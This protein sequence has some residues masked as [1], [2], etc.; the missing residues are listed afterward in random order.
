MI[1]ISICQQRVPHYRI[2]V[3]DL[4]ARQPGIEV[5]VF[6]DVSRNAPALRE[7]PEGS[8]FRVIDAPPRRVRAVPG[9]FMTHAAHRPAVDPNRFDLA[10]MQ[11]DLH[12]AL[13][14]RPALK[15]ARRRGVKTVLWG[16][17]YSKTSGSF[18]ATLR[19]GL[20]RRADGVL[21]YSH[22][23]AEQLRASKEV[24]PA[25]IFVAQNALD[26]APIARASASWRARG[27]ELEAFRREHGL[28][29]GPVAVYV[30]RLL[31][32]NRIELLIDALAIVNRSRPDAKLV[33]VGDGPARADLEAQADRLGVADRL[34]FTG[35]I[36]ED[37]R[38]APWMLSARA[39]V[40][41]VNI[42]L[43]LM[44]AMGY[45]LPVITSDRIIDHGPEV[46]ALRDGEN[47]LFY[48]HG[49]VDDFAS[50]W[51]RVIEDE[52]FQARLS[53]EALR[54]MTERYTLANMVQ[55]FLNAASLVDGASRT[56]VAED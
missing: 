33:I 10:V 17:G 41:P 29:D 54:T 45:G 47:G 7:D 46:G 20:A 51:L 31:E 4:L 36:F 21:L 38:L 55:G 44:H 40:Y 3:F 32:E 42:G 37:E 50:Q 53:A 5:T 15:R 18:T 30:S 27:D 28:A 39:C 49:N 2:P 35:A 24:D 8:A 43:S 11:W 9:H 48:Q 19:N 12:Y 52:A 34:I 26:Q 56:V 13:T 1:R 16:H 6:C 23:V 14:L 22:D 25:R